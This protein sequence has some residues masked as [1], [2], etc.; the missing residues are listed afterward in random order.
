M[1]IDLADFPFKLGPHVLCFLV[2][3]IFLRQLEL[4]NVKT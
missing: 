4:K 1:K 2:D 3:E